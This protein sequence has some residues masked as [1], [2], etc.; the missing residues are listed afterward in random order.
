MSQN[1]REPEE[2]V[3]AGQESSGKVSHLTI[4]R[5]LAPRGVRGELRV[6]VLTDFPK[7]FSWLKRVFIDDHL[8]QYEVERVRF[9]KDQVLLKLRDVDT[10]EAAEPL[11]GKE[12]KVPIEEAVPLAAG[13]YYWY[14]IIGLEVWTTSGRRIGKVTEIL[15][16]GANDV[17]VVRTD[18]REVLIPVIADVIKEIA[19]DKGRIIIEPIPGMLD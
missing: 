3:G 7:R 4:G 12:I 6:Q 15:E 17:Y 16:T 5:I 8:T 11:R 9:F 13:E 1:A 19:P 10:P 2:K 14:E 18:S